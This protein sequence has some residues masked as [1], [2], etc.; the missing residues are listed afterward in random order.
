MPHEAKN[1]YYLALRRKSLCIPDL[2]EWHPLKQCTDCVAAHGGTLADQ[3]PLGSCNFLSTPYSSIE[4]QRLLLFMALNQ[5]RVN[6]K[7]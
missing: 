5:G 3:W 2:C 4:F 6:R 1:I 7:S